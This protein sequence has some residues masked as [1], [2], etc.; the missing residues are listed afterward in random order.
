M[1]AICPFCGEVSK[2]TV[3][4]ENGY[5]G[6]KCPKC[7]LIFIFP[8]PSEKEVLNRHAKDLNQALSHIN[9]YSGKRLVAKHHLEIVRRYICRG[10]LLEIGSGSGTFLDE[11]KNKGFDVYGVEVNKILAEY[12]RKQLGIPCEELPLSRLSFGGKQL[13]ITY[14]RDVLSHFSDPISEFGKIHSR[15]RKDG[16]VVFETGNGG[17]VEE[18]YYKFYS[19]F[20]YPDH[21]F[22][23]SEA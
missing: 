23:F 4:E 1:N 14:H 12:I 15:L 13:D 22:L 2:R 16:F 9:A 11:A 7:S 5:D 17:D 3:I 6:R 10:S 19:S 18:R 8:R 21:L 20:Q